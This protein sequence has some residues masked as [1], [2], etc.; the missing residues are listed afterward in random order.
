MSDVFV[1]ELC[2]R[3]G[4]FVD[5]GQTRFTWVLLDIMSTLCSAATGIYIM[6]MP[7]QLQ[8]P[9]RFADCATWAMGLGRV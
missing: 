2:Y 6:I 9:I 1:V 4:F 8:P 7:E 3:D 5:S